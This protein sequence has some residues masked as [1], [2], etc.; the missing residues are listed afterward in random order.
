MLSQKECSLIISLSL[1]QS[2][3]RLLILDYL[4]EKAFEQNKDAEIK[5]QDGEFK[6]LSSSESARLQKLLVKLLLDKTDADLKQK[7]GKLTLLQKY[8][9][10]NKKRLQHY[11]E[12]LEVSERDQKKF[13][14][15]AN[16]Y[17]KMRAKISPRT[18]KGW[19]FGLGIGALTLTLIAGAT[20]YS[21]VKNKEDEKK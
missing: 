21:I 11:R 6:K 4:S 20:V 7:E 19:G 9:V 16:R 5:F 1:Y 8:K 12:F 17:Q 18:K 13:E 3:R 2:I 15:I 14:R 10:L